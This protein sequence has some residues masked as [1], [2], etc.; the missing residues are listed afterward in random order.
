MI[1]RVLIVTVYS[2]NLKTFKVI[3]TFMFLKV[4]LP[5]FR[6]ILIR[7]GAVFF[8]KNACTYKEVKKK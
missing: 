2:Y 8:S 3:I 7:E 4:Q 5:R 6:R 1:T